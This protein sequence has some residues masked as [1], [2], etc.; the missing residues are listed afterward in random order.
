MRNA[1]LAAI[2]LATAACSTRPAEPPAT[3]AAP[4]A[5]G[6]DLAAQRA[7]IARIPMAPNAAFLSSEEREV[8]NLLIEAAELM[9]PIYLRQRS[10]GNPTL[11][12]EMDR[13]IVPAAGLVEGDAGVEVPADQQYLLSRL[14]H[15]LAQEPEIV[16]AVDDQRGAVGSGDPPAIAAGLELEDAAFAVTLRLRGHGARNVFRAAAVPNARRAR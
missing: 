1:V 15:R 12:A 10:V 16:A 2:L 5:E 13:R 11:R 14:Q 4:T 6:Y 3:V 9:N 7:K 8:V